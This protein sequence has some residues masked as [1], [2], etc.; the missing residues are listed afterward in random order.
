MYEDYLAHY[1]ILGMKWGVRRFQPYSVRGRKSG[2]SG[3]EVGEAKKK[4]KSTAAVAGASIGIAAAGYGA[5]QAG[6]K[7]DKEKMFAQTIK[8]GKDKP[9]VSPAEKIASESGKILSA[10]GK[11]YKTI[12][13]KN[14]SS[15]PRESKKLSEEELKKRIQRLELEKRYEDLIREDLSRGKVSADEVLDAFGS[16]ATIAGSTATIYAMLKYVGKI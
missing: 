8:G 10:S 6:K 7:I 11:I 12:Q 13:K 15:K 3:K 2:K 4:A 9:P 14:N 16:L 1:G 5:Y